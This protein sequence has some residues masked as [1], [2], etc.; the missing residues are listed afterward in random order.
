MQFYKAAY[1][2][3]FF[4]PQI[5]QRMNIYFNETRKKP[6]KYLWTYIFT[7]LNRI[8]SKRKII[9]QFN[10]IISTQKTLN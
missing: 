9:K 6:K 8:N 1:E 4:V 5:W 7:F 3:E 10:F 2:K